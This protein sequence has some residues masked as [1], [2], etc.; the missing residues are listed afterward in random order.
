MAWKPKKDMEYVSKVEKAIKDRYGEEATINPS[1]LWNEEKEREYLEQAKE[2]AEKYFQ[3]EEDDDILE[4]D[5]IF[6]SKKLINKSNA[7]SCPVCDKYLADNR[8]SVYIL[9]WDCCYKCFINYVD[10]REE[11]WKTGWRPER[12]DK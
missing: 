7:S 6:I 9:K 5:G 2:N 4:N 8:D 11:R 3:K 12:V 10:G 1:S